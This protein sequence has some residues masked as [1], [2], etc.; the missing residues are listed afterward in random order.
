MLRFCYRSPTKCDVMETKSNASSGS[1]PFRT[2]IVILCICLSI[3]FFWLFSFILDDISNQRSP[4][5]SVIEEQVS[6]ANLVKKQKEIAE[7]ITSLNQQMDNLNKQQTITN[8]TIDSYRDTMNQLLGLEKTSIEKGVVLSETMKSNLANTTNLYL[9]AQKKYQETQDQIS[10]LSQQRQS[11]Q[12]QKDAIAAILSEQYQ[13]AYKKHQQLLERFNLKLALIKLAVLIPLILFSAYILLRDK[14]SIYRPVVIAFAVATILKIVEVMNDYFPTRYF[15]YIFIIFLILLVLGILRRMLR[16]MVTP[17]A[18]WLLK[19]FQDSYQRLLCPSCQ[20]PIRPGVLKY[21]DL[22]RENKKAALNL[23]NVDCDIPY[24]CP[25]CGEQLMEH[26]TECKEIRLSLLPY[27][28]HC[29]H[30]KT[31]PVEQSS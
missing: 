7:K 27:C 18:D 6:D 29:R 31:A 28:E 9:D 14:K 16:M 19:Q 4:A 23:S 22:L 24:A 15:K 13:Q 11:F 21:L 8:T 10:I 30:V 26:C 17:R 25:S 12:T 5:L 3:L 20:Y 2:G 1:K